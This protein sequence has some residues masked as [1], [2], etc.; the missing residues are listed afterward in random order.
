MTFWK[1]IEH[2]GVKPLWVS[3]RLG[4]LGPVPQL[5]IGRFGLKHAPPSALLYRND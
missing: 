5:E 4:A 1:V 2:P 3:S